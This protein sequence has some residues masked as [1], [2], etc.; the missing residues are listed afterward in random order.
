MNHDDIPTANAVT[1]QDEAEGLVRAYLQDL[2]Q[3][4]EVEGEVVITLYH[5]ARLKRDDQVI[6]EVDFAPT[7]DIEEAIEEIVGYAIE[8][9]MHLEVPTVRFCVR[10]PSFARTPVFTLKNPRAE[11][12]DEDYEDAPD[13]QGVLASTLRHHHLE[14]TD[15]RRERKYIIDSLMRTI[16]QKDRYIAELEKGRLEGVRAYEELASGRHV[17]DMELRREVNKERR[18]DQIGSMVMTSLP[19]L[20]GKLM[21]GPQG[22]AEMATQVPGGRTPV[23]G[24]LDALVAT[25]NDEQLMAIMQANV[26]SPQ[27]IALLR[28]IIIFVI[29]RRGK[30]EKDR[31]EA[32]Q[33]TEGAHNGAPA[34]QPGPQAGP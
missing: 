26:F 2:R 29:E 11:E 32:N 4:V 12:S 24:M 23:E 16:E 18:M 17:R 14:H 22:A 6:G 3:S 28:D 7:S 19:M 33:K 10:C 9:T 1:G 31:Q 5:K 8:Y 30:E 20:A 13:R 15:I 25:M 27:Q 21:G 34:Q